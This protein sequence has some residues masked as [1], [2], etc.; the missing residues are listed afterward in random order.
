MPQGIVTRNE[1]V[2]LT[3]RGYRNGAGRSTVRP[4]KA[5]RDIVVLVRGVSAGTGEAADVGF[6]Q[7]GAIVYGLASS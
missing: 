7:V 5:Y 6:K 4:M 2:I 3:R 1:K